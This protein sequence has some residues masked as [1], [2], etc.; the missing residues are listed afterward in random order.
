MSKT[1]EP[2]LD[3]RFQRT[4]SAER[5]RVRRETRVNGTQPERI[6]DVLNII[7][8]PAAT[9]EC[10]RDSMVVVVAPRKA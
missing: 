6:V 3:E 1:G 2:N 5:S 8:L 4:K 10:G 9:T 7:K